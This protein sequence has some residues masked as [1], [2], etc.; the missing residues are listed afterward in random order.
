A[1]GVEVNTASAAL[2]ARVSG[3]NTT[4]ANNVVEFRN[5]HGAFTSRAQLKKVPRFGEKTFEHAAR[6][7]RVAGGE[8]PLDASAVHPESYSIV[9]ET[10]AKHGRDSRG[11]IGASAFLRGV[12]AAEFVDEKFGL[13]TI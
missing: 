13:P 12:T 1:V 5:E 8:N 6:F 10:A 3:L 9:E 11:L 7:L 2:L 4:L